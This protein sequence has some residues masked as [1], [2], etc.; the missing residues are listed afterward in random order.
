M[1]DENNMGNRNDNNINNGKY[2]SIENGNNIDNSSKY[3]YNDEVN[4]KESHIQN[5]YTENRQGEFR[6]KSFAREL[7][8]WIACVV[9]AIVLA[10][11]VRYYIGTPTIVQHPSMTPTL[12]SG[13][14][15]ILNRLD[16]RLGKELK[17]GDIVT[18]EAPSKGIIPA[19]QIEE[20]NYTA[21][22]NNEPEG[23]IK[24]FTYY[25]L[26]QDKV[27]YIKRVIAVAGEH[28]KIEDGVVYINDVIYQEPY[29]P[30]GTKT[31]DGN[32]YCLDLV[33]PE[34]TVFVMGDNRGNSTDSR[35]FG[36]IPLEKLESK[37]LIR[38]WP[39]D[40]FGKVE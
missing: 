17:K 2:S 20:K 11:L 38:F 15:L 10:L 3:N 23:I 35:C 34:G 18:F 33:V 40:K 14:R 27:S 22:Y 32:G 12:L 29:L 6:K 28:I 25:V 1:V 8:E 26:E 39:F 36:C 7:I 4:R 37:V 13:E 21:E 16:I 24:K 5:K 30:E 9:V 19:S 31:P